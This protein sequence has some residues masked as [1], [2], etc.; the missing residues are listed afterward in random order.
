MNT[1][2]MIVK[3]RFDIKYGEP[4]VIPAKTVDGSIFWEDHDEAL[5]KLVRCFSTRDEEF[6]AMFRENSDGEWRGKECII[7]CPWW[8]IAGG[9]RCA[10][11]AHDVE[12]HVRRLAEQA[13][14]YAVEKGG[15]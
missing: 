4:Q 14:R 8:W 9:S 7:M 3:I 13:D 5:G 12:D 11:V 10:E 6:V 2:F 15:R 1:R